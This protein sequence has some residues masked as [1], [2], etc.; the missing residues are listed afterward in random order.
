[1]GA[2]I[3]IVGTLALTMGLALACTLKARQD[4]KEYFAHRRNLA[5][6]RAGRYQ[7]GGPR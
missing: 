2:L 7:R 6:K 3:V 4:A 1:M 5:A